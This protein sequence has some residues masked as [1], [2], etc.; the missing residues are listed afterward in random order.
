MGYGANYDKQQSH[1]TGAR[2]VGQWDKRQDTNS[3]SIGLRSPMVMK[4]FQSRDFGAL[5]EAL[6][7]KFRENLTPGDVGDSLFGFVRAERRTASAPPDGR[8]MAFVQ[9]VCKTPIPGTCKDI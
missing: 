3:S 6:I 4:D 1:C 8:V 7:V 2:N 5:S 9:N